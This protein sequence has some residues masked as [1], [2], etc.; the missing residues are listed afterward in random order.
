MN[1]EQEMENLISEEKLKEVFAN[2]N[3]GITSRRDV[4]KYAL[5][6][7]SC[8]YHNGHTAQCI[9]QELG[10]VGKSHMKSATLTKLGKQYLWA[11]FGYK[12][13]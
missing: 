8:G 5:L 6:K 1:N 10:L 4:V 9:I 2:A 13:V 7:S 11:C 3:F 12:N